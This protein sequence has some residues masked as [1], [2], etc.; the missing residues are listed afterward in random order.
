MA[1]DND[2]VFETP[3]SLTDF[4]T[5]HANDSHMWIQYTINTEDDFSIVI[6]SPAWGGTVVAVESP[7]RVQRIVLFMNNNQKRADRFMRSNGPITYIGV[8]Y[9]MYKQS[10]SNAL[11]LFDW[12]SIHKDNDI[13]I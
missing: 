8:I 3:E 6:L 2:E 11:S 5:Q 10:T 1:V 4:V 13:K 12:T 7:D 9:K